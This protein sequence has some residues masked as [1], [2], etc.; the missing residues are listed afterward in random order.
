MIRFNDPKQKKLHTREKNRII[1]N[2]RKKM[3]TENFIYDFQFLLPYVNMLGLVGLRPITIDTSDWSACLGHVQ[4]IIVV[5]LLTTGY[6]IQYLSCF[7]FVKQ[8]SKITRSCFHLSQNY[9]A[10]GK[11][12]KNGQL[13]SFC[14]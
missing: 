7:R 8:S 13:G 12:T 3:K 2:L 6:F 11:L 4:T 14:H 5:A 9:P 1:Y 10:V